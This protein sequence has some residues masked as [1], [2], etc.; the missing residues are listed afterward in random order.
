MSR[1][2][3]LK[4]I[5]QNHSAQNLKFR[6]GALQNVSPRQISVSSIIKNIET[7][8]GRESKAAVWCSP[9]CLSTSRTTISEC[10]LHFDIQQNKGDPST[11][12]QFSPSNSPHLHS[13]DWTTAPDAKGCSANWQGLHSCNRAGRSVLSEPDRSFN[14]LTNITYEKQAENPQFLRQLDF[15]SQYEFAEMTAE[16]ILEFSTR[17]KHFSLAFH[18]SQPI[19]I[20]IR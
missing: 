19:L 3:Q 11:N 15:I 4:N 6:L 8:L 5:S 20:I 9:F 7:T 2:D 10:G 13:G 16:Q 17:D 1:A 12:C 18:R 14:C